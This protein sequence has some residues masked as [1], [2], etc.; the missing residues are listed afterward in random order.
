VHGM[1]ETE[2]VA[3]AFII[4]NI[5]QIRDEARPQAQHRSPFQL[6]SSRLVP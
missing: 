2:Q 1:E 4:H 3:K 5:Y 6:N